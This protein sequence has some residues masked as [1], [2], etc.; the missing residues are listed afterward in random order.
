MKRPHSRLRPRPPSDRWTAADFLLLILSIAAA[1]TGF[2]AA[3]WAVMA[4]VKWFG[5]LLD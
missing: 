1:L 4:A 2:I 3:S 5:R